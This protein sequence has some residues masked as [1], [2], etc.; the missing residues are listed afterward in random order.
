MFRYI[1]TSQARLHQARG[2][3]GARPRLRGR[4]SSRA[5]S[6]IATRPAAD[7]PAYLDRNMYRRNTDVL[8]DFGRDTTAAQDADD[9]RRRAALPVPAGEV[10]D[11][12]DPLK[13]VSVAPRP[14][15]G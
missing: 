3:G 2:G 11:V 15:L 8:A 1:E 9:G 13:P 5:L 7:E 10:I 6:P 12:T 14:L 4:A